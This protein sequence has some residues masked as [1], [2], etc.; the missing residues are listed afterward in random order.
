MHARLLAMLTILQ[1]EPPR[2]SDG[3]YACFGSGRQARA[4]ALENGDGELGDLARR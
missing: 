3:V 2:W 1:Q 4:G